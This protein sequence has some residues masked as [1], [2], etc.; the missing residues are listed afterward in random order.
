[1]RPSSLKA[2]S[3]EQLE[4]I[5]GNEPRGVLDAVKGSARELGQGAVAYFEYMG[6]QVGRRCGAEA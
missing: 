4:K 2:E 1:M 3:R 6:D 5:L